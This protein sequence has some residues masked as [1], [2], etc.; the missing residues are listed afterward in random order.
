MK[1]ILIQDISLKNAVVENSTASF[2]ERLE[3][4]K[5]LSELNVDFIELGMPVDKTDEVL[6]KTICSCV[7]KCG[8]AINCPSNEEGIDKCFSLLS[9][10]KKKK[11]IVSIPVSPVQMEYFV[12]KKPAIVLEHLERLTK[13]AHSLCNDIEVSLVDATR[14]EKDFLYKAIKVAVENGAKTIS[15]IDLSGEMLPY[16]INDFI[17]GIKENISNKEVKISIQVS[18][19]YSYATA[20]AMYSVI[21][22]VETIKTTCLNNKELLNLTDLSKVIDNIGLKCGYSLNINKTAIKRIVDRINTLSSGNIKKNVEV[23]KEENVEIKKNIDERELSSIIKN[24]GYDLSMED[25]KKVYCEYNRLSAKK[26]VTAKDIDAIIASTALQV[27]ETYSLISFS[28]NSSNVLSSTA[29][30]VLEKDGEKI[31]GLS[32]GN[33]SVDAAF[34]ALENI[35]GRHFELDDFELGAV[36]EGKEAVGQAIVKLR[37]EGKIY[38]GKGVSTDIVG[39]SIRAYINALNKIVYEEN[40]K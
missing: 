38:S 5:N 17:G 40:N 15:I 30:V 10:A 8:I 19:A 24:R 3:I 35:V 33:G 34:L 22:G 12:S 11:L 36:T 6:V 16:E 1:N 25:S 37:Y 32:F 13:K 7:G 23:S 21:S 14:A 31:S 39:A 9:N 26:Q 28:V 29:S 20:S 2:R 18:N 27:P 4:A